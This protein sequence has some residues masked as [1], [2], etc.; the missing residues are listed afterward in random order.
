M[1][2][3][4]K[5]RRWPDDEKRSICFQTTAQGVSVAQVARRYAMNANLIFN[6]KYELDALT[7]PQTSPPVPAAPSP[8]PHKPHNPVPNR[9]HTQPSA[10]PATAPLATHPSPNTP[11]LQDQ[12]ILA[13]PPPPNSCEGWTKPI[14]PPAPRDFGGFYCHCATSKTTSSTG[15]DCKNTLG[16]SVTISDNSR[17][18]A[19]TFNFALPAPTTT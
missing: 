3:K 16:R 14:A 8:Y 17:E 12:P 13:M 9:P 2:V 15:I 6:G 1:A 18:T 5:K 19:G 11:A 4:Q 7:R 10:I